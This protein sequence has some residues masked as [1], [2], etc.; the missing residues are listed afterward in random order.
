[1]IRRKGMKSNY[2][3]IVT[4]SAFLY[5]MLIAPLSAMTN[6][7]L[8]NMDCHA[9][10]RTVPAVIRKDDASAVTVPA[11]IHKDDASA[12][13]SH[14]AVSILDVQNPCSGSAIEEKLQVSIQN[15]RNFQQEGKLRLDQYDLWPLCQQIKNLKALSVEK[16]TASVEKKTA[17]KLQTDRLPSQQ[18]S[19][20]RNYIQEEEQRVKEI[21]DLKNKKLA[22]ELYAFETKAMLVGVSVSLLFVFGVVVVLLYPVHTFLSSFDESITGS[23]SYSPFAFFAQQNMKAQF[24]A[25]TTIPYLKDYFQHDEQMQNTL[26]EAAYYYMKKEAFPSNIT[27]ALVGYADFFMGSLKYISSIQQLVAFTLC[28]NPVTNVTSALNVIQGAI[29]YGMAH[30]LQPPVCENA[31]DLGVAFNIMKRKPELK[32]EYPSLSGGYQVA[33]AE[34]KKP[35]LLTNN[36]HGIARREF[37]VQ[38]VE[39]VADLSAEDVA[40]LIDSNPEIPTLIFNMTKQMRSH[41]CPAGIMVARLQNA[42]A[43]LNP[44][45]AQSNYTFFYF[46]FNR[47]GALV[48]TN[49]STSGNFGN[50]TESGCDWHSDV[51]FGNDAHV[52]IALNANGRMTITAQQLDF[53]PET[54]TIEKTLTRKLSMSKALADTGTWRQTLSEELVDTNTTEQSPSEALPV[55]HTDTTKQSAS[56]A[57]PG[58]NTTEQ[59]PSREWS[60]T[61]TDT[62]KQSASEAF[63]GTN[64]TEQ[65]PSREWSGTHTDTTKQSA[66]EALPGTNTTEQSPSREWSG[67]HT[68]TTKQSASEAFPGTNTTEQSPS[69]EWSGTHTDTT[70]QSASEALPGTNT[71]EQS[72]S[73]EWSGTHTD[74][75]KQSASDSLAWSLS[76]RTKTDTFTPSK[77]LNALRWLANLTGLD[78]SSQAQYNWTQ[79]IPNGAAGSPPARYGHAAGR[80][81]DEMFIGFG[82]SA[83]GSY[84]SDTWALN[85][86]SLVWRN[87]GASIPARAYPGTFTYNDSTWVFQGWGS[88]DTILTRFSKDGYQTFPTSGYGISGIGMIAMTNIENTLYSFGGITSPLPRSAF[89]TLYRINNTPSIW[90]DIALSTSPQNRAGCQFAVVNQEAYIFSGIT[91][92]TSRLNDVWKFNLQSGWTQLSPTAGSSGSPAGRYG[93]TVG[94]LGT[95]IVIYGGGDSVPTNDLWC[96]DTQLMKW[97]RIMADGQVGSLPRRGLAGADF[98]KFNDDL[99]IFGGYYSSNNCYN[100]LWR[101]RQTKVRLYN[102]TVSPNPIMANQNFTLSWRADVSGASTG[103]LANV[104][105]NGRQ[106]VQTFDGVLGSMIFMANS[107]IVNNFTIP[108][109]VQDRF[110]SAVSTNLNIPF[111]VDES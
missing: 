47:R 83:S 26:V 1:M 94:V 67:T 77:S 44:F 51:Q 103:H 48:R 17:L 54:A 10:V 56:E 50:I 74:T 81:G 36:R 28:F 57:F 70:K 61:H 40:D 91:A 7:A 6:S 32:G 31:D 108:L 29:I 104:T 38:S 46:W 102:V 96:L 15:L 37:R 109:S 97:D 63:P 82:V 107:T 49:Y 14:A 27:D 111:V 22:E 16:K 21:Q 79:I 99:Y 78:N 43:I 30:T 110:D 88:A 84:L 80:M 60:G 42:I 5:Q 106:Y 98:V 62:T 2:I 8:P 24:N 75:T 65:S 11:V 20:I 23:M 39:D 100:D 73:R 55:T 89:N 3:S 105:F 13:L 101:L 71:T 86:T 92:S 12:V 76:Q 95:D 85:L 59:S 9:A 18:Q 64:T 72:P 93:Y 19:L 90:Q 4:I 53:L 35:D 25:T 34:S 69:R 52:R 45:V 41:I 66:S 58:T 68:D 33:V 87:L